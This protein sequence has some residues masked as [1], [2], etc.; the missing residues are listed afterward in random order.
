MKVAIVNTFDV[1]DIKNWSGIPYHLSLFLEAFFGENNIECISIPLKRNIISYVKGFYF[2]RIKKLNYL[3]DFDTSVLSANYEAFKNVRNNEYNL[4]ITFQ[5]FIIPNIENPKSKIILWTDATFQNL[6]NFY[7]YVSNLPPSQ[8][9]KT[10]AIQK[11]ALQLSSCIILTSLWA[12]DSAVKYYE[13][14][15]DKIRLIPFSS[16]LSVYPNQAEVNEI[17]ANRLNGNLKLLFLG[18]DWERK[19]GDEAVEVLN[20]LN[21][22]GIKAKLFIIGTDIL[23]QHTSNKNIIPLGFINKNEA[24]GEKRIIE[25]LK[26]CSLLILPTRADCTPVAFIEANSY[27]LPVITTNVGGIASVIT[28]EVNGYY[29]NNEN[30]VEQAVSLIEK[31]WTDKIAYA[32]LCN[33]SYTRYQQEFSIDKLEE[34]F[35]TVVTETLGIDV[36]L[37]NK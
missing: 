33:S 16:N 15:T 8:I 19:G 29:F 25:L 24:S 3:S 21:A 34:K 11:K 9:N 22:K 1:K 26:E 4:I 12:I 20:K 17:I 6:L 27:A 31:L 37:N 18:V 14:N 2:N 13:T 32:N 10:H 36:P 35:K 23:P 5:F 28:N 7:E 30:F